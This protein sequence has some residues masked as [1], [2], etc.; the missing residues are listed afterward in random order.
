MLEEEGKIQVDTSKY[1]DILKR[2]LRYVIMYTM[3][4]FS[5]C[6]SVEL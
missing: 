1:Q 3:I 2:D 6:L 4:C 5:H